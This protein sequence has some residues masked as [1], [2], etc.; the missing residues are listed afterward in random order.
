MKNPLIRAGIYK[1][2]KG[3]FYKVISIAKHTETKEDMVVYKS[4]NDEHQ[5]WVRPLKM[6]NEKVKVDGKE[7][8]RFQYIEKI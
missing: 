4:V 3:G 6:F 8:P 2:Y 7:I 1:H 5:L